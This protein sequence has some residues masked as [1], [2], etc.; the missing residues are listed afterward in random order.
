MKR[1]RQKDRETETERQ[2]YREKD[3]DSETERQKTKRGTERDGERRKREM[4]NCSYLS[5]SDL[6]Q[7]QQ[8]S[9]NY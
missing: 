8:L 2:K 7:F 5:L 6:S 3:R 4:Y 1:Q 9:S